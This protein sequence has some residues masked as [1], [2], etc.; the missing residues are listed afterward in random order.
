MLFNNIDFHNV[1]EMEETE[2]GFIMWRIP[3]NI[4]DNLN[5][6]AKTIASRYSTG[7][8]LRFK[9][10]SKEATIILRAD[11]MEEAQVAYIYY[12]SFQGGW[13]HSTKLILDTDTRITIARSKNLALLKEIAYK[14]QE[15]FNP[16]LIRI[17][18][19]YGNCYFVD[20]EGDVEPPLLE[21]TPKRTY[22]AYGSSI[23]H[24]SLSL[25]MPYTYPFRISQKLNCDYLNLGF[26]GS[27]HMEK[28]LANYIV[29]RRD[30]D[31]ASVEMGINMIGDGFLV[32][33]FEERIKEFIDILS[34]DQRP[35]FATSLFGFV[36]QNQDKAN[37]YREIV[38][39][40][41]SDK[42]HF[43]DGLTLLDNPLYISEDL[44]HP[45]LEGME[46]ISNNWL[47]F[48]KPYLL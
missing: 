48:I 16:E 35:I 33:E 9:L 34:K 30:W 15:G 13:Q 24:G 8:E 44:V 32:D 7:I 46:C 31:F 37:S 28:E 22:L 4:R 39:K 47:E 42:L 10:C 12:G 3:K 43:I 23:T 45:T 18:L 5:E 19:P 17:I 11:K 26:A 27:A 1:E 41:A 20:I 36:E 25:A 38:K 14:N 29:S 6:G 2:K 40:Y 21:D